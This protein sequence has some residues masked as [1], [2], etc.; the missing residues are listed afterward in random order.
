MFESQIKNRYQI[1]G[2]RICQGDILRDVTVSLGVEHNSN[3]DEV[4]VEYRYCN[5]AVVLSQDCDLENDYKRVAENSKLEEGKKPDH[6]NCL[7]VVL[8]CPAYLLTDFLEG[9][10]IASWNM[11]TELN[12]EKNKKKLKKNSEFKRYHY[13]K[14]NGDLGVPELIVDFKHFL[15]VPRDSLYKI[16][17]QAYLATM[18]ELFR[19]D[20]SQRFSNFISRIGLPVI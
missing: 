4:E 12:S 13:I 3:G 2:G 5:Y 11:N 9:K 17:N 7:Q 6:D 16:H 20:L 14:N 19:E 15:T 10:H 1:C 18:G 8:V